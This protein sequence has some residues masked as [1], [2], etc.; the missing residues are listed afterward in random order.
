MKATNRLWRYLLMP[1]AFAG[2]L[3]VSSAAELNPAA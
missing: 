1:V 2:M 3:S